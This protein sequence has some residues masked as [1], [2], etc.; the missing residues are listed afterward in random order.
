MFADLVFVEVGNPADVISKPL[1]MIQLTATHVP[2]VHAS[3][4][5]FGSYPTGGISLPQ[6]IS[7]A[8]SEPF[9]SGLQLLP[10]N[11][12]AP[13][14]IR[15]PATILLPAVAVPAGNT[16]FRHPVADLLRA[17]AQTFVDRA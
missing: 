5:F 17:E 3:A 1:P 7:F 16:R 11:T 12:P 14:P 8:S 10:A 2:W 4:D 13:A 15:E 6:G 9:F